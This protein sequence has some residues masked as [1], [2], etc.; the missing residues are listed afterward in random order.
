M[1][2]YENQVKGFAQF[3]GW[4]SG[5]QEID[6]F[7]LTATFV[8]SNLARQPSKLNCTAKTDKLWPKEGFGVK[9]KKQRMY[10]Q[11]YF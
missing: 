6:I 8:Y 7:K 10:E 2:L 9:Y 5:N 4:S 11:N 1:K 3:V